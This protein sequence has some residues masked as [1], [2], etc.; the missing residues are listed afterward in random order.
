MSTVT[1]TGQ[2]QGLAQVF[3]QPDIASTFKA[4]DDLAMKQQRLDAQ[5]QAQQQAVKKD[6][7][8]AYNK[9]AQKFMT[10]TGRELGKSFINDFMDVTKTDEQIADVIMKMQNLAD[11]D[12]RIYNTMYDKNGNPLQNSW[13]AEAGG[14]GKPNSYEANKA[15]DDPKFAKYFASIKGASDGFIDASQQM[16]AR[17]YVN[18]KAIV[19]AIKSSINLL[20]GEGK[21]NLEK[22]KFG[23]LIATTT[24]DKDIVENLVRKTPEWRKLEVQVT[25]LNPQEADAKLEEK[26]KEFISFAPD[27]TQVLPQPTPTKSSGGEE[28]K[29]IE[30]GDVGEVAAPFTNVN[31]KVVA[32]VGNLPYKGFAKE[33]EVS[34]VSYKGHSY[35]LDGLVKKGDEVFFRGKRNITQKGS[36]STVTE[37]IPYD[38]GIQKYAGNNKAQ[39]EAAKNELMDLPTAEGDISETITEDFNKL[40][41][42]K[43]KPQEFIKKNFSGSENFIEKVE[44]LTIRNNWAWADDIRITFKDGTSIDYNIDND[45]S[46]QKMIDDISAQQSKMRSGGSKTTTKEGATPTITGGSVR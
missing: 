38:T 20:Y 32:S 31:D 35:T 4:I 18:E 33:G 16:Q 10:A 14:I 3:K 46:M 7:M 22:D 1:S 42:G 43:I 13:L 23:K 11:A 12:Q 17:E 5:K 40:R 36:T 29:I 19:D 45:E 2:G 9:Q 21:L 28:K 30:D 27:K 24:A 25:S 6:R 26:M 8:A 44:E 37:L 39:V 41:G 34:G 15:F